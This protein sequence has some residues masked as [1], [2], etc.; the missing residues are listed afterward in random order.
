MKKLLIGILLLLVVVGG[1]LFFVA[2][3]LDG[4]VKRAID[5]AL[6]SG[7]RAAPASH[8]ERKDLRSGCC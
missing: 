6:H 5:P 8:T 3:N 7:C 4:I 2:S 1:A